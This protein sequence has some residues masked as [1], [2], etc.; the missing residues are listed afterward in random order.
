[1][2]ELPAMPV[3]GRW[4]ADAQQPHGNHVVANTGARQKAGKPRRVRTYTSMLAVGQGVPGAV[5]AR[6]A[7][8][9]HGSPVRWTASM[10]LELTTVMA[11]RQ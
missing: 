3:T 10:V 8:G 5:L 1:M 7:C 11:G 9:I 4:G 6:A 2:R